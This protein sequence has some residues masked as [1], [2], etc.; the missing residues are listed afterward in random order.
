MGIN[1]MLSI[2]LSVFLGTTVS[3]VVFEEF[4]AGDSQRS[5][6]KDELLEVHLTI[7]VVIQVSHNF[8]DHQGVFAA[9]K[10]RRIMM[11]MEPK[12]N[13]FHKIKS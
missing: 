3:R 13:L 9:L 5:N 1:L 10:E 6:Q 8:L 7:F 12:R 4:I 2:R 11:K